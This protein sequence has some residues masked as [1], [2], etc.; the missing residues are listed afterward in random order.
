M[1]TVCVFAGEA[2]A[3]YSFGEDHPLGGNRLDAFMRELM[4]R[5]LLDKVSVREPAMASE[6]DVLLFHSREY[7]DR[8]RQASKNGRGFLDYSD[9]PAFKGVYEASLTVVGTTL[10]ALD[11]LMSGRCRRA[12]VPVAGLHHARRDRAGGF[13]VFNDCGVAIEMIRRKYGLEKVAYVD[14]DAHHGDGVY[15]SFDDDPGLIFVD[16]HEDGRFL[17]PG[18]GF[19]GETGRDDARGTKMNVPLPPG[20]TD[21]QLF[22]VWAEAE[23]FV[24]KAE[25]QIVLFQ[26]GADGLAGDPI[27]HL[28]YTPKVHRHVAERLCRIAEDQCEGR[29]LGLGGGGYELSNLANAWCAV[30]E[31]FIEP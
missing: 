2:L 9:T 26:C 4:R 15:Y 25:P 3:R 16:F 10:K 30:V 5:G 22:E 29:L 24:R 28:R 1:A 21:E 12:F 7:V 11:D 13:C 20:A 17:Y 31:A 8:V 18:T 23:D 6:K 27:T 19:A 14:I